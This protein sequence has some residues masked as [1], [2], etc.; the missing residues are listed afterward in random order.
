M[1]RILIIVCI[2]VSALSLIAQNNSFSYQAVVRD[3]N[4]YLV[5]NQTVGVK[6]SFLRDFPNGVAEYIETHTAQTNDNGL[7]TLLVGKGNVISGSMTNLDLANHV[8]YLKSEFDIYGGTNYAIKDIQMIYGVPFAQHSANTNYTETQIINISNDTIFLTGGTNSIVKL[9]VADIHIPDSLS[10]FVNDAGYF[11]ADSIPANVSFFN[12]DAGYL[13]S[14]ADSQQL[15]ISGDTLKLERSGSIVIPAP[16]CSL[17]V[18]INNQADSLLGAL[19]SLNDIASM[20]SAIVCRPKAAT[21]AVTAISTDS[22]V[23]GGSIT[24]PCGYTITERGVCWNTSGNANLTDSHASDGNGTGNFTYALT[25]LTPNTTYYVRAYAICGNDTVYGVDNRFS[26]KPLCTDFID[27]QNQTMLACNGVG[28]YSWRGKTLT[29]SGIYYDSLKTYDGNCDSIYKLNFTINTA[30]TY[31]FTEAQTVSF[32]GNGGSYSWRGK[33][34]TSSGIYYDSLTTVNGCD[35]VYQLTLTLN[36]YPTYFFTE[37]QTVSLCGGVG[38]YLWHGKSLTSSGVYYD[39]LTTVNGCDS[40]YQLTLTIKALTLTDYDNN[41]YNTIK[42]GTQCWMKDNLRTTRYADGTYIQTG[43]T[44]S[45]SVAYKYN[46]DND[47][48]T[49]KTYGYLYNWRAAMG[50]SPSSNIDPSG[51]QGVCPNGWHLPSNA[52]WTAMT[53][54]VSGQSD[55]QC[56]YISNNIAKALA[57]TINWHSSTNTCAIGNT[58]LDNN[59]TGFSA[60]PASYYNGSYQNLDYYTY[61]WSTTENGGTQAYYRQLDYSQPTVTNSSSYKYMGYSVRC[62]EGSGTLLVCSDTLIEERDTINPGIPYLWHGKTIT[63]AGVHYDSLVT[64]AGCDSIFKL[65]LTAPIPL[66]TCGTVSDIDGNTYNT[67][68]IGDQCWMRENL[69]TTRYANGISI[70]M[71][72]TTSSTTGYRYYPGNSSTN[73]GMYGYLYNWR[74]VMGNSSSSSANPSNVQGVCPTGWHVPSDAEWTELVNYVSSQPAYHYDNTATNIAKALAANS[75]WNQHQH[76]PSY[77]GDNTYPN[78]AA[79]FTALPA[80]YMWASSPSSFGQFAYFWSTTESG[81]N[82]RYRE[83]EF[84][85]TAVSNGTNSKHHGMSVRC[86]KGDGVLS[87]CNDTVIA[88]T[89]TI[90][91]G[92]TYL[93]HNKSITLPGIYFD[94]LTSVGGCDS[95]F[96][97]TLVSG[98][99]PNCGTVTDI[100]GNTYN[101]VILDTL[102]WMRE[103][104]RTTRYAD[105]TYIPLSTT[106]STSVA[107]RYYPNNTSSTVSEHGY[108]YNWR[109]VMGKS[110]SSSLVPSGVQG[111]CP[112][113]WHVPSDAEWTLLTNYVSSQPSYCSGGTATFI[114]KALASTTS[115]NQYPF[116]NQYVVGDTT[117]KNNATNFSATPAGYCSTSS[118]SWFGHYAY[119]WTSTEN[120]TNN[121]YQRELSY[122]S[123]SVSRSSN[124]KY[125]EQSV[126]CVKGAGTLIVCSDTLIAQKGTINSGNTYSWRGRTLSLPGI[127]FD[128]L[129]TAYGCDSIYQLTLEWGAFPN[130]GTVTDIDGN[131]YNTIQIGTQCWMKENLKV[132][133]YADGSP[134]PV[135]TTTSSS[136]AYLYYPNNSSTN[137]AT[138]GYLYNWRAVMGNSPSSSANPSGIQGVCP[139]GWHVPSDAEL[140]TLTDYISAQP[141][142]HF[143]VTASYIGKAL[144]SNTGWD[145]YP[146]GGIYGVGDTTFRNDAT[147][148]SAMPAGYRHS[149]AISFHYSAYIWSSTENGTASAY[150]REISRSS[151]NVSRSSQS[152]E[153]SASVR[154]VQGSGVLSSC[155]DTL[156]PQTG[157]INAGNTYSWRG[158]TLSLAGIYFDSLQTTG[159]CDS[160]YQLILSW[161]TIPNCG[162]VTD[163]DNNTYN[164]VQIG[165]QCW[166]RENLRTTKYA[167]N[168]DIDLGTT[169]STTVAYIYYPGNSSSN[170]TA[171][172]YLYNWKA[173]M[174]TSASSNSV[175][176][177][178]QGPCPNGWHVPSDAEWTVLTNYVSSQS[179]YHYGLTA[180]YIAKS[181]ASTTSN[182]TQYSLASKIFTVGNTTYPNNATGFSAM[183][184]GE[185]TTASSSVNFG[186]FAY[187]WSSTENGNNAMYR[188]L[189]YTSEDVSSGSKAKKSGYSVR[190][191]KN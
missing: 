97:I 28:S 82:A 113:G 12:N 181:L 100:D 67:V 51:V 182:W 153:Y 9:P 2:F 21:A 26:T 7:I 136:V 66:Y 141:S 58:P 173:V 148:F 55:N 143:S 119:F 135:G 160:I 53:S 116:N 139:T 42:I 64:P 72:S 191:L 6:I 118:A 41:V 156:I 175:P 60:L 149:S 186:N 109:A 75:N 45:T 104:L 112:N 123:E 46:P 37:A 23:C 150:Y 96:Q 80:G 77:V 83:I 73:V 133:K 98:G 154:C 172:G 10:S 122:S 27:E 158:R 30:Q 8:Y 167:D 88:N 164:T 49:V 124:A 129:K 152:K 5:L 126:R 31:L 69:R 59:N 180:T 3:S 84:W 103:N 40:V 190:C 71:G 52:E 14:S 94:S 121:A 11:T 189:K 179:S 146:H 56:N 110:P 187:F 32:C 24:S 137:V 107:Y 165:T 166:M 115:W 151:A 95:I 142:Y 76:G 4:N 145:Y 155:S 125:Y 147:G 61:F 184:A 157:T 92:I 62:V 163:I 35:S 178:V 101:T 78:N 44:T 144:A 131:T 170:V 63:M 162:T 39:S 48:A 132:T 74:A 34:L 102:C 36:T 89:D 188:G 57:S 33:T 47:T 25:N 17:A 108:L 90:Y 85:G 68:K 38:S 106:T 93:W 105:G 86:V 174:R 127:Y 22:A 176:S 177:G 161:G 43:T 185:R 134:I 140:T 81:N 130:C 87:A 18:A 15:S 159:G 169:T 171:Y 1:K 70:Y 16:C 128:S 120:G 65:I 138:Y 117:Y 54:Y 19:D 13:V 50:K 29:S 91:P 99:V 183:P 111:I 79:G 168:T 20:L 114:A